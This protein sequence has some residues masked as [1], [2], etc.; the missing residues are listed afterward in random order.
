M[1]TQNITFKSSITRPL[2]TTTRVL[3]AADTG[4]LAITDLLE[5]AGETCQMIKK[6]VKAES[7]R[8]EIELKKELAAAGLE[9]EEIAAYMTRLNE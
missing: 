5:S 7:I 1:K 3:D 2:Q 4:I 9:D 8:Q 6:A